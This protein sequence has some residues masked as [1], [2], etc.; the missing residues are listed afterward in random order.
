MSTMMLSTA[1]S[2]KVC[3]GFLLTSKLGGMLFLLVQVQYTAG[4]LVLGL[5]GNVGSGGLGQ[6]HG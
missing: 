4:D 5:A 1:T 6:R 3:N 2:I